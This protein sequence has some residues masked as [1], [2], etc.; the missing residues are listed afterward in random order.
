MANSR[1]IYP[2]RRSLRRLEGAWTWLERSVDRLAGAGPRS[3]SLNPFYHLGTLTIFLLILLTVTGLYLTIFYR[4]GSDRA[5]ASILFIDASWLGS[6]MR[7]VHRYTSDALILVATLHALKM[8]LS[9]R[10]WG[11]RW[12]AWVS[13]WG[14]VVLFWVIGTMGYFL[15][16]DQAAQWLMDYSLRFL[17]GS[18]SV[19]FLGP[20]ASSRTFSFFVII[21]F[22]HVF[23]P[24]GLVLGILV[25][26]M[27]LARTR[28]WAP[29]WLM[30]VTG[31]AAVLVGL[32]WP[33]T[34]NPAADFHN[35]I[36]RVF[37]DWWYLGFLPLSA[38]LGQPLFWGLSTLAIGLLVA[39]PWIGRGQHLG[40]AVVI[41]PACTGCALCAREC[42]YHAVEM[43]PRDDDTPFSTIA[44]MRPSLCT[45]CGICVAACADSAIELEALH[46]AVVRQDLHRALHELMDPEEP[47]VVI[48][49]CDRHA[50]LASLPPLEPAP[51]KDLEIPLIPAKLPPRVNYGLWRDQDGQPHPVMTAMVPCM[52]MLHPTW[53]AEIIE[54]G[55]AG[56]IMLT[57]PFEDCAYR[58]G[59]FWV[60]D[61]MR[62]RRTL[63]RGNTHLLE[64]A[65][66]SSDWVVELWSRLATEPE[67]IQQAP[68]AI[69]WKPPQEEKPPLWTRL[70]RFLPAL[71][72]MA[73][74]FLS[75][76]VLWQPARLPLPAQAQIR[77]VVHHSGKL[78]A[79]AR[80]LP[81]EI[82]AKLPENVDPAR[83]LGGKR[84][85]VQ[86]RLVV[87][88]E[89]VLEET[90]RPRG[91]RS[92]GTSDG[93]A[94]WWL[95]PGKHAVQ[96]LLND[97][98]QAWRSVF[99]ETVELASGRS[100]ILYYNEEHDR[101]EVVDGSAEDAAQGPV[102]GSGG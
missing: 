10:F 7:T 85:P 67:A 61:R 68:T 64:A 22:L 16:W 14:L 54:A 15:V 37:V 38:W 48:Y 2:A 23:M 24:L 98:G 90:F 97:E 56:T 100:L 33:V 78:M 9:D 36:S 5:Y 32:L 50:A 86:V 19:S 43:E 59:P 35:L 27:R 102:E 77:L 12:L 18:L 87:D 94:V 4:P 60:E 52:G 71:V 46:A 88:G 20:D 1:K 39:L 73:L 101:F 99:D 34:S 8:F 49:A 82:A 45:G 69:Q 96:I 29:R 93:M 28:Y 13:G 6:L 57:C 76:L 44:V 55:A 21:L 40:P 83:V 62:R 81:P 42:P 41:E 95:E 58:E 31:V 51:S 89:E 79:A 84:F 17:S 72:L 65:P 80:E 91:L 92:E 75:G 53:A 3:R 25:H 11:S 26:G 70:P 74:F 30:V 47:P 63:R 66:G